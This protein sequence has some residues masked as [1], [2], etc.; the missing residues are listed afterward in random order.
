MLKSSPTP[1][2]RRALTYSRGRTSIGL[3]GKSNCKELASREG[4]QN[5]DSCRRN[6]IGRLYEACQDKGINC[7]MI[8]LLTEDSSALAKVVWSFVDG[9][10]FLYT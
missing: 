1:L 8:L 9:L 5:P 2:E 3:R 10:L 6:N 4:Q 7:G